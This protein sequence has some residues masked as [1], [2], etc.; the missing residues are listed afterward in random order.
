VN[1]KLGGEWESWGVN[2]KLGGEWDCYY[3][4]R[5]KFVKRGYIFYYDQNLLSDWEIVGE[6]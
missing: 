3:D 5:I 4:K 2:G 6:S 1:G